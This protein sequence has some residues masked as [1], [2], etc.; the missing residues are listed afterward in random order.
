MR[1]FTA[2]LPPFGLPLVLAV[3]VGSACATRGPRGGGDDGAPPPALVVPTFRVAPPPPPPRPPAPLAVPSLEP[4]ANPACVLTSTGGELASSVP[5]RVEDSAP[6]FHVGETKALEVRLASPRSTARASRSDLEIIGHVKLSDLPVQ[7]RSGALVDGYLRV[8]H[9]TLRDGDP[10]HLAMVVKPPWFVKP[11]KEPVLP[12]TCDDIALARRTG[13]M[14]LFRSKPVALRAGSPIAVRA[15]PNG[16]VVAT[17][18]LPSPDP[19]FPDLGIDAYELERRG[20][21]VRVLVEWDQADVEGWVSRRDVSRSVESTMGMLLGSLH[22]EGSK[23]ALTSEAPLLVRTSGRVVRVGTA[24]PGAFPCRKPV[25]AEAREIELDSDGPF[26]GLGLA[27][28]GAGPQPA[29][30]KLFVAPARGETCEE[31]GASDRK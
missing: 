23:V 13:A 14:E 17:I 31:L 29:E 12:V 9:A 18:T 5:L 2:G 25:S 15:A 3:V 11:V 20:E 26:A 6:F 4:A 30:A 22:G 7:L 27:G 19:D 10:A 8:H 24:K 21:Q 28:P 16:A 1:R